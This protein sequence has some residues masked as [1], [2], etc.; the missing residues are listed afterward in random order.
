MEIGAIK[1][2]TDDVLNDDYKTNILDLASEVEK[3][4]ELRDALT[5]KINKNKIIE[6]VKNYNKQKK[7]KNK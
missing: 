3:L 6:R 4:T 7:K 1:S 5:R 2:F